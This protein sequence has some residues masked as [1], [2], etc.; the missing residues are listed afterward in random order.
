[1]A[2]HGE[3]ARYAGSFGARAVWNTAT[4][5]SSERPSPS[6]LPGDFSYKPDRRRQSVSSDF[7]R[8]IADERAERR[9]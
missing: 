1:M 3:I 2:L 5:Y 9:A 6:Q 8:L 7:H 4:A